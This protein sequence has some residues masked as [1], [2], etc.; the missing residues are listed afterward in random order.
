MDIAMGEQKFL[1]VCNLLFL[2]ESEKV[3]PIKYRGWRN[4]TLC[5]VTAPTDFKSVCSKPAA[6]ALRIPMVS[7]NYSS[8]SCDC[9]AETTLE[10]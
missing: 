9:Q 7:G 10:C 3:W 6:T 8:P 1:L 5:L 2:P 4:R